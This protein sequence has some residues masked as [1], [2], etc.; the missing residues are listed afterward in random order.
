MRKPSVISIVPIELF[1]EDNF[2]K[3]KEEFENSYKNKIKKVSIDENKA[4]EDK[5]KTSDENTSNEQAQEILE[6]IKDNFSFSKDNFE[7]LLLDTSDAELPPG[8]KDTP[9]I[10]LATQ[11]TSFIFI[12]IYELEDSFS[13]EKEKLF[14][15]MRKIRKSHNDLIKDIS[16]QA[17]NKSQ[18]NE[19]PEDLVSYIECHLVSCIES[20]EGSSIRKLWEFTCPS[21]AFTF[22]YL[23]DSEENLSNSKTLMRARKLA[24]AKEEEG[25]DIKF[26]DKCFVHVNWSTLCIVVP[27]KVAEE[28]HNYAIDV[29]AL[30]I[31]LQ[32][33]WN[34]SDCFSKLAYKIVRGDSSVEKSLGIEDT[35]KLH[36]EF[37]TAITNIEFI[38]SAT[39]SAKVLK[40]L[41][42]FVETSRINARNTKL[43][44]H[45]EMLN[46]RDRQDRERAEHK[47]QNS[48]QRILIA[49]P[50]FTVLATIFDLQWIELN[51]GW[52]VFALLGLLIAF[53]VLIVWAVIS[54]KSVEKIQKL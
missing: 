33:L 52:L 2:K 15:T 19:K 43:K 30:Q 28:E 32:M 40:L 10:F 29:I 5:V 25:Q 54:S 12:V 51:S 23:P 50:A 26:D 36:L 37:L 45:L 35:K 31:V 53:I 6:V 11:G 3:V 9:K 14:K 47:Y 17:G 20:V 4:D 42:P 39:V 44:N 38:E 24:D 41:T 1:T 34:R 13:E 46:Y 7:M 22:F 8:A 21:Y 48:I 16:N 27:D 49:L 18:Q